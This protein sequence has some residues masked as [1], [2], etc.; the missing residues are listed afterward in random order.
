MEVKDFE[1]QLDY[2]QAHYHVV[3]MQEVINAVHTG[4][5]LP[6]ASALL[7]FDDG[8]LDHYQHVFPALARRGLCGAFFPPARCVME[9]T[10][11]DVNKIHFI[12][13]CIA[14]ISVIVDYVDKEVAAEL[15][16]E[17]LNVLRGNYF[18]E[19]R[20]DTAAVSYIKKLLQV[21]LPI[22]LRERLINA[23][24]ARHVS[25][26]EGDFANQLYMDTRQLHEMSAA[27]HAIGGHGYRHYWMD[28]LSAAEQAEDI[29]KSC[30]MLNQIGMSD[31][32]FIFCYPYGAYNADTLRLLA[33]RKCMA[34]FT[35]RVGIAQL[36]QDNILEIPRL[37][38]NDLP[39]NPNV[40]P[41]K[42]T[43]DA[44]ASA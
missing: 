17:Q 7:T 29:D 41:V 36:A 44:R 19:S 33:E 28:S 16:K 22:G 20:F 8:Y 40:A 39:V 25:A 35:S 1:G 12:L 13:A 11:L 42:W 37:D 6:P 27:G 31:A 38:T 15:G 18:R 23:L 5:P 21:G 2:I 30:E 32:S 4:Q 34:A 9:R 24:F 26:D 10:M 43:Q 14:D 3:S